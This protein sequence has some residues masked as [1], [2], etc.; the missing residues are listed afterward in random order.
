MSL[1]EIDDIRSFLAVH[2]TGGVTTAARRL[3]LSKSI[4]SRRLAR[5]EADLGVRLLARTTRGVSLTAAGETYRDHAQRIVEAADAAQDALAADGELRGRLRITAPLAIGPAQLAPLFAEFAAQHARLEMHT[6]YS[7][8]IADVVGE[9]FD[10]AF[11]IGFPAD[12]SLLSRRLSDIEGRLVASPDY[13]A[14]RGAPRTL[15][16]LVTHDAVMRGGE[17]WPFRD[18]D[19]V[20]TVRPQGRFT[21]DN[22]D[23][24]A[25]A[26]VAG[27]GIALLPAA[28]TEHL[29]A[30]GHL[31]AVLPEHPMPAAGLFMLRPPGGPP[32]RR[33]VALGDFI[34]ERLSRRRTLQPET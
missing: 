11:R 12:S 15:Q 5:L 34:A 1:A 23:A 7:D 13:L 31:A 32:P 30:A 24:L 33:V 17:T 19:R 4:V 26:A 22:G 21:A 6:A 25:A 8:Q 3:G 28:L 29:L 16:D 9:G 20:V 2:S 27:L 10:V 14:R 18:G